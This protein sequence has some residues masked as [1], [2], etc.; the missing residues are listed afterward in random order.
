MKKIRI[1]CKNCEAQLTNEIEKIDIDLSYLED[2]QELIGKGFWCKG[3]VDIDTTHQNRILINWRDSKLIHH[4]RI[5]NY[6]GCC[7]Y[8]PVD[9]LNQICPNC[10]TGIATIVNE[11]YT[12]DYVGFKVE[13]IR[14]TKL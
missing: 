9:F 8:E 14:I 2:G 4:K 5:K 1:H 12:Y 3:D 7:G 6:F 11:C 10:K 13:N